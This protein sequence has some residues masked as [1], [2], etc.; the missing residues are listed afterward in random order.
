MDCTGHQSITC[1]NLHLLSDL[2]IQH[3]C[4]PLHFSLFHRFHG[5]YPDNPADSKPAQ[6]L[7]VNIVKR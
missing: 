6:H 2:H 4:F 1:H 7:P 3:H 5:I